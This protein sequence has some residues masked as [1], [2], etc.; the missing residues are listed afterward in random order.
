MTGR[1]P[2][3]EHRPLHS[4]EQPGLTVC[5]ECVEVLAQPIP[6]RSL[7]EPAIAAIKAALQASLR[8]VGAARHDYAPIHD[9]H[10]ALDEIDAMT[11]PASPP[12]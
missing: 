7:S 6:G 4:T 5:A 3:C 9:F 12:S 11:T 10:K 8:E 1:T 2:S